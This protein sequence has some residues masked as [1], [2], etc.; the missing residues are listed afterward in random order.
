MFDNC[1]L[2]AINYSKPKSPSYMINKQMA[3]GLV[4][5]L[6]RSCL[7]VKPGSKQSLYQKCQQF[8]PFSVQFFREL[9]SSCPNFK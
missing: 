9:Q 5:L 2:Y 1:E 6:S 8:G 3:E 7:D 4:Q